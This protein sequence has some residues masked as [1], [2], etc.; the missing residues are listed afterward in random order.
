MN[1][2]YWDFYASIQS[3]IEKEDTP[4][5]I[6]FVGVNGTGKTTT[7]AKVAHNLQQRGCPLLLQQETHSE[8]EQSN[9]WKLIVNASISD[10]FHPREGRFGC[11][12]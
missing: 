8:Q 7:V 12:R 2:G 6:M 4:V 10:V 3:F 5:V 11:N 1:A 9:N